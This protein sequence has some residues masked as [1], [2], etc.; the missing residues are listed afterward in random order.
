MEANIFGITF[1]TEKEYDRDKIHLILYV[2]RKKEGYDYKE[3]VEAVK[4]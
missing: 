2:W 1:S 3:V 4:G